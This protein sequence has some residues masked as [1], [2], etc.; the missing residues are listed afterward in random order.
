MANVVW[1]DFEGH[2][3]LHLANWKLICKE[4]KFGGFGIPHLASVNLCDLYSWI[5]R[6]SK[7]EGKH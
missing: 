7:D 1:N 5:K 4:N 2:R 6:Y 3:K